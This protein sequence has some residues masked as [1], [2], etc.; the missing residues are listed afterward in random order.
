MHIVIATAE[1]RGAYHLTPLKKAINAS[2]HNFT[3]LT[4]Y[5]E[6]LQGDVVTSVSS[7]TACLD[8]A[9]VVVVTGGAMN[10]WT[11]LVAREA[12]RLRVRVLYSELAWTRAVRYDALPR[13]HAASALSPSSALRVGSML[14][15]PWRTVK[16]TG[17]PALDDLPAYDPLPDSV[18]VL[19]TV[20][21]SVRDPDGVLLK[22]AAILR[23]SGRTV[24]VRCHPRED[25]SIWDGYEVV[26]S[27]PQTFSASKASL[28][29]GYPGSAH[30]LAAAVGAPVISVEPTADFRHVL[31][32]QEADLLAS[33]PT[34]LQELLD[35]VPTASPCDMNALFA[36]T[37]PVGGAS[38]RVLDFW[39]SAAG[40]AS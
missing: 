30:V 8:S 3:H 10:P 22:A 2:L 9:D 40:G 23:S 31:T 32:P 1:P 15:K 26:E 12:N 38:D 33:R 14:N 16:V 5:P 28:V 20:D 36:A 18:L 11:E 27:E 37:G 25:R 35:S 7:T 13:V 4:P 29:I 34:T 21:H 19:S 17:I 24:R 39:T 6:P